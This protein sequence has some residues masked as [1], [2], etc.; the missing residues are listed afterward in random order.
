MTHM[1]WSRA[2]LHTLRLLSATPWSSRPPGRESHS[3]AVITLQQSR[4]R[5][6]PGL[7][8]GTFRKLLLWLHQRRSFPMSKFRNS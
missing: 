1:Q 5:V 7:G 3:L 8:L 2:G 6:E 4:V